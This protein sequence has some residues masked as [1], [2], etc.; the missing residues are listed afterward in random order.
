MHP[1]EASLQEARAFQ[2]SPAYAPYRAL[3]QVAEHRI[4]RLMQ[5]GARK[6]RYFGREKTLYQLLVAATV[7]NLTLVATE[8]GLMRG[9]GGGKRFVCFRFSCILGAI[10]A[11][12]RC[13][14]TAF[15]LG[16]AF[17]PTEYPVSG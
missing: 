13:L 8:T 16:A 7:A 9:P 6:A 1:Q 14:S 10:R 4:T 12:I 5:L 17:R 3:R 15:E 2:H 11:F